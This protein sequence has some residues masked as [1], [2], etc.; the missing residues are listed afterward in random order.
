MFSKNDEVKI[1]QLKSGTF[2]DIHIYTTFK[3][4]CV[5]ISKLMRICAYFR[6][7]QLEVKSQNLVWKVETEGKYLNNFAQ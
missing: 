3:F 2:C 1:N 4:V 5:Q 6:S 7:K